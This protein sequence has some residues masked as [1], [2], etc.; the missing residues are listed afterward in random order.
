MDDLV[1]EPAGYGFVRSVSGQTL[2]EEPPPS[3][4]GWRLLAGVAPERLA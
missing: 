2:E 3:A 4:R 1:A